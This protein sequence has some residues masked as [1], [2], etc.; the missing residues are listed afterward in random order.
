MR[1]DVLMVQGSLFGRRVVGHAMSSDDCVNIDDEADW[2][3]AEA[4]ASTR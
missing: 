1:R 3:R 4:L 2:M